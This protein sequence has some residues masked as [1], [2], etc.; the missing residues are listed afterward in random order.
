MDAVT[1]R[2]LISA[3]DILWPRWGTV[4]FRFPPTHPLVAYVCGIMATSRAP[5]SFEDLQNL[6][7]DDIKVKVAGTSFVQVGWCGAYLIHT[8]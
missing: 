1:R 5:T 8:F 6:L 3:Y 2:A 7:L 4:F